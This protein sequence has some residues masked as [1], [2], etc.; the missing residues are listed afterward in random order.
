MV[1]RNAFLANSN[2]KHQDPVSQCGE[3]DYS[4]SNKNNRAYYECPSLSYFTDKL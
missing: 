3:Q 4:A 2:P 1:E